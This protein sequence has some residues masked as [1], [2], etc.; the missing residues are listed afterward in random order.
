MLGI[1]DHAYH[2]SRC[3]VFDEFDLLAKWILIGPEAA[4]HRLVNN[5]DRRRPGLIFV[6]E[7]TALQQRNADGF[8]VIR[9]RGIEHHFRFLTLRWRLA[10]GQNNRKGP[11]VAA[12]RKSTHER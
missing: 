11:A 8:K 4:R 10:I 12:E 5:Y 7:E 3:A 9:H 1:A 2:R 6:S